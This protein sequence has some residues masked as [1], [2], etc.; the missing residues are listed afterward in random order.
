[1]ANGLFRRLLRIPHLKCE[2]CPRRF[3]STAG[4]ANHF[5]A[6]HT[7]PQGHNIPSSS[8]NNEEADAPFDFPQDEADNPPL[9]DAPEA[10]H[11]DYHPILD[12]ARTCIKFW[13][14]V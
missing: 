7:R 11:R 6:A 4:L 3:K 14:K 9:G 8:I 2:L 13:D 1:M 10:S 5:N 12:G